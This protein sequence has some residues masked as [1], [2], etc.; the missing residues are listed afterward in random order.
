M[1]IVVVVVSSIHVVI[2]L[3]AAVSILLRVHL[4]LEILVVTHFLGFLLS[5]W[6]AS[7]A[8]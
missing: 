7:L 6:F 4:G 8:H 1:L 3:I 2:V 5:H